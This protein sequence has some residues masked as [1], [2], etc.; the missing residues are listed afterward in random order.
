MAFLHPWALAIGI[1]AV[2]LPVLVHWLT[3]PRPRRLPLSTMRFVREAIH[4]RRAIHRLRDW[5][6]LSLRAIAVLLLAWAFSRPLLGDH[7]S[8]DTGDAGETSR[9]VVLD[10]SQSMAA[11][12]RGINSFERARAIAADQLSG[13]SGLRADLILAGAQPRPVFESLSGNFTDLRR[14]LAAAAPRPE[15]CD[16][17]KALTL[18]ADLLGR[19]TGNK[20]HRRELIVVTDL[21]EVNWKGADFSVLPADTIIRLESVAA[22][23]APGNLAILRAGA[24]GRSE[25]GQPVRFEVEVGD[26]SDTPRNVI[27]DVTVGS[28][29]YRL[30]GLCQAGGTIVL[31][32]DAMSR[33]GG[34]QAGEA[35]L[36]GVEDAVSADNSRAFVIEVRKRPTFALVTRE[37]GDRRPSS[38]Y[39]L[40]RA[41]SPESSHELAGGTVVRIPPSQVN[42]EMLAGADLLVVDRPGKLPA[43]AIALLSALMLR[44]KPML[45]VASE[46]TDATN[47]KLITQQ[48]G[49]DLKM[50]VE[51][52][53]PSARQ[54]RRGLTL[55]GYRRDLPPFSVFGPQI[56]AAIEPLRFT[57]GLD[58]R[59]IDGGLKEDVLATYS[60]G[61]AGLVWATS[62]TGS[63]VVLNADLADSSLA[64]SAVFVPL[65]GE[66]TGNLLAR[67]RSSQVVHCGDA[68]T[69]WLPPEAG[70]AAGLEIRGPVAEYREL[71]ELVDEPSGVAWRWPSAGPPGV[72]E[73]L[74]DGK[75]VLAMAT[76]VPAEESNLRTM[77]A[78]S[79]MAGGRNVQIRSAI[80][81]V[82]DQDDLWTWIGVACLALMLAE[83]VA[84]R[85]FRT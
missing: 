59:P 22:E 9:V 69:A 6:I 54:S 32:G 57:R 41:L 74:R 21:Q 45:Y 67:N 17:K 7:R 46:A 26:Y 55:V 34:W 30:E 51:F 2:G 27:V 4:Q 38:S 58:S 63:L 18:A 42:R 72:Y 79:G 19:A 84:L 35:R 48:C 82:K 78:S 25:L 11:V 43:D 61:T 13:R 36:L 60:D 62:G 66:L 75:A 24:A 15:R 3:R 12:Q 65:M 44:G 71:G 85:A 8:T 81:G 73:V 56:V 68:T 76:A 20:E 80:G 29:S 47:L 49:A 53:P 50:P 23:Q 14:E 16:V 40:E 31:T 70:A 5:I 52:S 10:V 33:D 37:E 83:L 64:R 77:P 28:G 39:F 1:A